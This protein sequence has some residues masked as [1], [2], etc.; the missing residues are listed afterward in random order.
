[1]NTTKEHSGGQ[2]L[3]RYRNQRSVSQQALA[4]MAHCSRSMIAQIEAGARLPSSELLTAVSNALD[5][6]TVE[7]A[8]LFYIYGK[9]ESGQISMLPYIIATIRTDTRLQL[10]QIE[11]LV[12]LATQEYEKALRA[13]GKQVEYTS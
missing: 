5:L 8:A 3:T 13:N 1:M 6:N 10:N 2:P 12:H 4:E 11:V 9:V 7:R